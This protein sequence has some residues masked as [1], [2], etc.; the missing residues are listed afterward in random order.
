MTPGYDVVLF[1]LD[2]TIVDSEPGIEAALRHALTTGFG[3]D[4]SPD[5]LRAFMGPPIAEI[6]PAVFGLDDPDDHARF[7]AH[8]C[9]AYFHGTETQFTVYPGLAA[10]IADLHAH[11]V[12]IVLATAKP[13]ESAERILAHAGLLP[14]FASVAGSASDGSRQD[15]I[16]VLAHA[17][18]QAGIDTALTSV[19]MIGDRALDARAADAHGVDCVLVT[20]GYAPDGEL[21]ATPAEHRVASADE[22]RSVLLPG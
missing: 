19:V 2:G 11:G 15:K 4:P 6:L 16:E 8:Y 21:E 1:D 14:C 10:L 3:I 5:Q 9:E 22:L 17:F 20:W 13:Q 18:A 12:R 7:F